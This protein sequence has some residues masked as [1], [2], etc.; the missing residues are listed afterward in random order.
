MSSRESYWKSALMIPRQTLREM[1][2]LGLFD[3]GLASGVDIV[4]NRATNVL[5]YNPEYTFVEKLQ[6]GHLGNFRTKLV[7]AL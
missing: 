6:I 4:D 5:C 3:K 7:K 2:P 1:F